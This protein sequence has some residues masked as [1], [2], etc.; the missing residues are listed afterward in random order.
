[1]EGK[2]MGTARH[3]AEDIVFHAIVRAARNGRPCPT[4]SELAA[5]MGMASPST[6][7]RVLARLSQRGKIVVQSGQCSR[8]VDI[9][10]LGIGTAGRLPARHWREGRGQSL[11]THARSARPAKVR[12]EAP[13]RGRGP[14]AEHAIILTES[15]DPCPYC[16]VR[17]DIGCKHRARGW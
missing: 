1:V 17:G 16:G 8:V 3:S 11:T 14:N 15:R 4:N 7:V 5:L 2:L 9:P 6:S 10:A 13:P 12:A